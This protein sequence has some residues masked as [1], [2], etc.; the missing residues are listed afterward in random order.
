MAYHVT[1]P[2]DV[3]LKK[4]K[5]LRLQRADES[6]LKRFELNTVQISLTNMYAVLIAEKIHQL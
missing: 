3:D 5:E 4:S 6:P 2:A 1:Y